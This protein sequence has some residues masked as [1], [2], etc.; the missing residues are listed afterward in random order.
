M[1]NEL[2]AYGDDDGFGVTETT[3]TTAVKGTLVKF[4]DGNYLINGV[5]HLPDD[6]GPF[7][8]ASVLT[9]WTRWEGDRPF[10]R[11]T[12]TGEQHPRRD[13]LPDQDPALWPKNKD[14][15]K[16]DP[17]Q[18]G[19]A[20]VLIDDKTATT[21]TLAGASIGMRIAVSELKDAVKLR[22]RARP[23][24]FPIVELESRTM[25]TRF[26][27]RPRP[28]LR[29]VGWHEGEGMPAPPPLPATRIPAA[30]FMT[31]RAE[32]TSAEIIG[33]DIPF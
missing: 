18:D 30:E 3:S 21:Y 17:W 8:V 26:G 22:R 10:H 29:V 1:S 12:R 24:C 5:D 27:D 20:T 25:P 16:T 7:T 14:N 32:P 2:A 9:M 11:I 28:H 23:N 6:A 33:D 19:R 4:R 13:E 15:V 31:R